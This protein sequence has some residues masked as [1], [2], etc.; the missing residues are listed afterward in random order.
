MKKKLND[1]TDK[2]F[3]IMFITMLTKLG[4]RMDEHSENFSKET[5]NIRKFQTEV[6]ELKNAITKLKNTLEGFR[7]RLSETEE[8][9]SVK[10][11][12]E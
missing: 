5:E 4:S 3:K 6:T 8:K 2:H 10:S 11:M 12:T 9:K 1:L 7:S